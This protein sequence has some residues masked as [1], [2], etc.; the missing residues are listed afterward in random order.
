MF[1]HLVAIQII[2][3]RS[4]DLDHSHGICPCSGE[5]KMHVPYLIANFC[6]LVRQSQCPSMIG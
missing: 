4:R 1:A 6:H 3:K 2:H 5:N